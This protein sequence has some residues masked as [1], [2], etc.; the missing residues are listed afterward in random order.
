MSTLKIEDIIANEGYSF[1]T[2]PLDPDT[3]SRYEETLDQMPPATV[4]KI[5][6][7][8]HLADGF[9]RLQA[10]KNLKRT[11]IVVDIVD[12]TEKDLIRESAVA[13]VRH[14]HP[15][16]KWERNQAIAALVAQGFAQREVAGWFGLSQNRVSE[17][18][19]NRLRGNATGKERGCGLLVVACRRILS[20]V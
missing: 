1:R 2:I 7:E 20:A 16:D 13:N 14:G 12:G 17:I 19:L 3:V 4:V 11:Q 8:Y 18:V 9:H 5:G 10:A 6:E 15:L